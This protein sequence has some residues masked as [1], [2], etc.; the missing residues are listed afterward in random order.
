MIVRP[1]LQLLDEAQIRQIVMD[2]YHILDDVGVMFKDNQEC[3][4]LFEEAGARVDR[5]TGVVK[6]P[7]DIIDR[8]LKTIPPVI[9]YYDK[10]HQHKLFNLGADDCHITGDGVAIYIQDYEN[11]RV[12]RPPVTQDQIIHSRLHEECKNISFTAPF[13]LTHVPREIADNYWF[14][15]DYLDRSHPTYCSAW[16]KEGFDTMD[17]M[18]QIMG[19]GVADLEDEVCL[20]PSQRPFIPSPLEPGGHPEFYGLFADKPAGRGPADPSCRGHVSGNHGGD[21]CPDHGGEFKR[22]GP[23][24]ACAQRRLSPLGQRRNRL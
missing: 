17:E 6:L 23:E 8:A 13:L 11:P 14:L 22:G 5:K 3:L 20:C 7:A 2:A 12:K 21:S 4:N 18:I 15:L 19:S 10:D 16:S 1:K 9:P 24:P